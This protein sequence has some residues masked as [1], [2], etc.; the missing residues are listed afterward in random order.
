LDPLHVHVHGQ[1]PVTD[2]AVPVE[3][4]LLVG[5]V[6]VAVLL[7]LPHTPFVAFAEQLILVQLL[8]LQ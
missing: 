8:P 5:L 2:D 3:H 4:K 1:L 7:A 6:D